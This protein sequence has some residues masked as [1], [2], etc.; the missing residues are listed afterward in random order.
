MTKILQHKLKEFRQNMLAAEEFNK[1]Y[2]IDFIE[3]IYK[4]KSIKDVE[5]E[6][7]NFIE[8]ARENVGLIDDVEE[9]V[10]M[11]IGQKEWKHYR[12]TISNF[13]STKRWAETRFEK[14]L[15]AESGK[16]TKCIILLKPN[17][18]FMERN[19]DV[20]FII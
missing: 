2:N 3:K 13:Y 17:K 7:M 18:E 14:L 1:L 10:R 6:F 11:K 16:L 15:Y 4:M 5:I 8:K 19:Y 20:Y 12:Q 9:D